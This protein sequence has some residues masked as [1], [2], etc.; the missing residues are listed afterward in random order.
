MFIF[1]LF[2]LVNIAN[3]QWKAETESLTRP[4]FC[5]TIGY[6]NGIIS[7]I[8]GARDRRSLVQYNTQTHTITT[9]NQNE[10]TITTNIMCW[11]Q[12]WTQMDNMLYI[13][14]ESG[15]HFVVYNLET[16]IM[17]EWNN[18]QQQFPQNVNVYGCVT[19]YDSFLFVIG[20]WV[21]SKYLNTN[22]IFNISGQYWINPTPVLH[23]S[24]G[25]MA[26]VFHPKTER[27]Y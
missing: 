19:M 5:Q 11:A 16:N 3:G 22:Q 13:S 10:S 23:E 26:C 15:D 18:L 1:M 6:Y 12:G 21:N 4:D 27:V 24:K 2:S 9:D 20:G 8:G 17:V 25:T 7:I 14:H